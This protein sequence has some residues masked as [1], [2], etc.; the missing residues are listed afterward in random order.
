MYRTFA[1]FEGETWNIFGLKSAKEKMFK[2]EI[3]LSCVNPLSTRPHQNMVW[4]NNSWLAFIKILYYVTEESEKY[5]AK[6]EP[7]FVT[8][9]C[10]DGS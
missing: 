6:N 3:V 7:S 10:C 9:K 1:L 5:T 2:S 4:Y 8:V